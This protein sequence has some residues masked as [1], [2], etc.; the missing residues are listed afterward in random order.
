[1]TFSPNRPMATSRNS[2]I[3]IAKFIAAY[4]VVAIHTQFLCDVSTEAYFVFNLLICRLAVPFFAACTGYFLCLGGGNKWSSCIRQE[5]KLIMLY[6]LWTLLY[7]FY[8]LPSW[9]E[10]D[11]FSLTACV[12][13]LKSAVLSGSY[14]HL[15][16]VLD[17]IYALPVYYIIIRYLH[18]RWWMPLAMV[19]WMV[20]ALDYGYSW[21]LPPAVS[22]VF[23]YSG[24]GYELLQSQF[25]LLPMMLAGASI[26]RRSQLLSIRWSGAL[27]LI[28]FSLLML[29]GCMLQSHG[30]MEVTRILMIQPVTYSLLSMLLAIPLQS[31]VAPR[32]AKLSLIIY[33]VH[34]MFCQYSNAAFSSVPSFIIASTLSTLVAGV[35]VY[36]E[37]KVKL[38]TK[39]LQNR[40][41]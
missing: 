35:W 34:P 13:Y 33:C 29:E 23:A 24:K 25:V 31:S 15:W 7:F 19:L 36:V 37:Y 32:L 14:F 6:L 12:G 1:M 2:T 20:C 40:N 27:L 22:S 8:L 21:L 3:D 39:S 18:Q 41:Y 16:Y 9:I 5:K 26:A 28:T 17:I 38:K 4:L 11:Y 30:H 10:T